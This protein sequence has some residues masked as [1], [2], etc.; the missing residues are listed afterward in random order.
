MEDFACS[1][2]GT[3]SVDLESRPLQRQ[4]VDS[5]VGLSRL[6]SWS[7][8][9]NSLKTSFKLFTGFN[10]INPMGHVFRDIQPA[11][12]YLPTT[13]AIFE[14]IFISS[15]FPQGNTIHHWY[16]VKFEHY[17]SNYNS[18]YIFSHLCSNGQKFSTL[19][20]L[21]CT[22]DSSTPALTE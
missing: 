21:W 16:P 19:Y 7:R 10:L 4:I 20:H 6:D 12:D 18:R 3:I 11:L 8:G 17:N 14:G 15:P 1:Q 5:L 22:N 9:N 13:L 2:A